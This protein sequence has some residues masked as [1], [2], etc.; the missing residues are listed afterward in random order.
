MSWLSFWGIG[1]CFKGVMYSLRDDYWPKL[2]GTTI[3]VLVIVVLVLGVLN[4]I[5]DLERYFLTLGIDSY[6]ALN[7]AEPSREDLELLIKSAKLKTMPIL[8]G[9]LILVNCFS[10]KFLYKPSNK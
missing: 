3:R 5:F 1:H 2:A 4:L 7:G 10:V 6:V 8:G 9:L